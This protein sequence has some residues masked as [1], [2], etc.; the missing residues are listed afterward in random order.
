MDENV[1]VEP[2]SPVKGRR[3]RKRKKEVTAEAVKKLRPTVI[4]PPEEEQLE[5]SPL[6]DM[7]T[8]DPLQTVKVS[9]FDLL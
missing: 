4:L 1:D 6:V 9:C 7:E 5:D 3:G 8:F 2:V